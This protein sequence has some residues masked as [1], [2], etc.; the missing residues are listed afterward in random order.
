MPDL[1]RVKDNWAEG[2][3]VA[4]IV[5]Y[6][7]L[8]QAGD[9]A[10]VDAMIEACH[11]AGLNPLPL[12]SASLKDVDSASIIADLLAQA[13]ADVILNMTSFAVS[14][15]G[16]EDAAMPGCVLWP[17]GAVDAPVFQLVL[18]ASL[19]ADWDTS[20]CRPDAA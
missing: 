1:S 3:P 19:A 15:P 8:L 20:K 11:A 4:A 10:P 14:D 2:A 18:S 5:F 6:R 12:F 13:D 17:F 16:H 7:A 9:L